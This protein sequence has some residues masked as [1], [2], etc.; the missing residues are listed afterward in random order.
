MNEKLENVEELTNEELKTLIDDL[1][2][3]GANIVLD[4]KNPNKP[5]KTELLS[6]VN[7]YKKSLIAEEEEYQA[8]DETSPE[9]EAPKKILKASELPR[10]QR[11]RLQT[12]DLFRKE[13]VLITDTR[14]T[15]TPDKAMFVSWGNGLI[16]HQTDV[17]NLEGRNIQYIRRGALANLARVTKRVPIQTEKSEEIKYSDEP[18]FLITPAAG[19]SFAELQKKKVEQ[20]I[21]A[22]N[23]I[24]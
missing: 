24:G 23:K 9:L 17:I 7:V 1:T 15:Q 10:S 13:C 16:G 21:K 2:D 18:R 12:A 22:A 20:Q 6:A 11:K 3:S 4:A 5:N 14:T 19:L 8:E